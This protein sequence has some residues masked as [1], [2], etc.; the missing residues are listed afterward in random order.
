[1]AFSEIKK[2]INSDLTGDPV[3]CISYINSIES[4]EGI[5]MY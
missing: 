4:G 3:N 2:T 5:L 1:M